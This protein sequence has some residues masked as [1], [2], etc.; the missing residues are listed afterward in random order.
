MGASPARGPGSDI[1]ERRQAQEEG[2]PDIVITDLSGLSLKLD[3]PNQPSNVWQTLNN[4]DLYIPGSIRKILPPVPYG[5]P[6]PTAPILNFINYWAQPNKPNG[7][8]NRLLGLSADKK[9]WDLTTGA[10]WADLSNIISGPTPIPTVPYLNVYP[11]YFNPFTILKWTP[12]TIFSPTTAVLKYGAYDGQLYIFSPLASAQ[13]G[14]QEPIWVAPTT[15]GDGQIVWD[16]LG[17]VKSERFQENALIILVPGQPMIF[18]VEYQLNPNSIVEP[19]SVYVNYVGIQPPLVPPEVGIVTVIQT[20]NGYS[21][22]AGRGFVYTLYNSHLF[23][24]SSPSPFAGGPV[25]IVDQTNGNA[26]KT[27]T[28]SLL[29]GLPVS[30]ANVRYQSYQSYYVAAPLSVV[31]AGI[32]QGC[33]QMY[34]YATR[35]GGATF[36]RIST[37]LDPNGNTISNSDGSVPLALLVQLQSQYGWTDQ[38]PLTNTPMPMEASCR[39]Y[40]GGGPV[41]L[42]PDP[43]NFGPANWTQANA[44]QL[45]VVPGAGITG[46]A[47]VELPN[48]G[49]AQPK[50]TLRSSPIPVSQGASYFFVGYLDASQASAGTFRWDIV[51]PDYGTTYASFAQ[52]TGGP[53]G[54]V[55]GVWVKTSDQY[56]FVRIRIFTQGANGATGDFEAWSDP[57]MYLGNTPPEGQTLYPTPDD[58]LVLPAPAA[59]SQNAPP[60]ALLIMQIFGGSILAVEV[61]TFRIWYSNWG[62]FLSWGANSYLPLDDDAGVPVL[63]LA[64]AFSLLV[65]GKDSSLSQVTGGQGQFTL[66]KVDPNHGVK[67]IRSSI[68]FGTAFLSFL[69][70]GL[71]DIS[72]GA[73][74]IVQ[75]QAAQ[76][77]TTGFRAQNVIGDPIK[78]LTDAIDLSTLF[79][80]VYGSPC[81]AT[82]TSLNFYLFSYQINNLPYVLVSNMA[83][84]GPSSWSVLSPPVPNA[85]GV[86]Q[87][88]E[89]LRP[90][91]NEVA[92]L[93]SDQTSNQV[94]V[95]FGGTQASNPLIANATTWYLPDLKSL[96]EAERDTVKV[97]H[98]MWVEGE[99]ISNWTY[100]YSVDYQSFVGPFQLRVRNKLGCIGRQIAIQFIHAVDSETT[101]MLSF[102]KITQSIRRQASG[103]NGY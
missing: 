20:V 97:F 82:D 70:T 28:G 90:D 8:T 9:I 2:M 62:D 98:E 75:Q 24:E 46:F 65:V 80:N 64:N 45:V 91:T 92:T 61:G 50:S 77:V 49:S 47:A 6:G 84:K 81:S 95:L 55:G 23:H 42:V 103:E 88:K 87:M 15:Y 86:V 29:P 56:Q 1:L 58:A 38:F 68:S 3:L 78:P 44:V 67:S 59:L 100:S 14:T 102:V 57:R 11:I 72:L 26:I 40:E 73:T 74:L 89:I 41:N 48:T 18:C 16:A 83:H 71:T 32:S 85:I 54:Y 36:Y 22:I 34:F 96:P 43:Q 33:D 27:I 35:D 60:T 66:T 52:A 101:P 63:E 25:N 99:D 51:S 13:S 4:C 53:P 76:S 21:P 79:T 19:P 94:W 37:L 93:L 17:T 39:V 10:L 12:S 7:P 69:N 30:T 31:Q 5:Q